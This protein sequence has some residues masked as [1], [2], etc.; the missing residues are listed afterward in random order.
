MNES[1]ELI[2]NDLNIEYKDAISDDEMLTLISDRVAWFLENDKDLLLSYLYRL[3]IDEER[4]DKALS[5]IDI[6]PAPIAIGKLIL[7]RQKQRIETKQR[8][9]VDPIEGWE[10]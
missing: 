9:K 1:F 4:I 2:Y 5:P 6:D 7:H 3:D 10:F 8:Y